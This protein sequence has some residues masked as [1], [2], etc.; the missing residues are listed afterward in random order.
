LSSKRRSQ[1]RKRLSELAA[2][3][4]VEFRVA[5]EPDELEQALDAALRL[6]ELRWRG[7]RDQS[8]YGLPGAAAF[9]RDVLRALERM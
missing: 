9:H 3:G 8:T 7:R 6:H 4:R 2:A 5:R 1:H